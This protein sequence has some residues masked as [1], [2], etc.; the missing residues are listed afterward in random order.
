MQLQ[1]V[2]NNEIPPVTA[3]IYDN[4]SISRRPQYVCVT[5]DDILCDAE[6]IFKVSTTIKFDVTPNTYATSSDYN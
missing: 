2:K 3:G 1:Y 4:H 6:N 5:N